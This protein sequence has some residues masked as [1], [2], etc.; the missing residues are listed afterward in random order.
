VWQ[1][2]KEEG[3]ETTFPSKLTQYRIQWEMKKMDSQY[4][5]PTKHD[6][7]I[8]ETCDPHKKRKYWKKSLRRLTRMYKMHSRNFK[9]QK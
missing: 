5:T 6:N 7:V 2:E 9:N 1:W 8:K 3:M 4:L